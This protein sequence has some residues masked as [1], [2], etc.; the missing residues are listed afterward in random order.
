MGWAPARRER[1]CVAQASRSRRGAAC[2]P[3]DMAAR[4]LTELLRAAPYVFNDEADI[5]TAV[6]A[7]ERLAVWR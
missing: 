7:V 5:A 6:V 3:F 4:G 1:S 2:A